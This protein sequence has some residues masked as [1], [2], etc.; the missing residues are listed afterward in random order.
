[1]DNRYTNEK[2]IG[3]NN[4][5]SM[6]RIGFGTWN[7]A[8]GKDV[9]EAVSEA[10]KVGYRLIDTASIY[11]NER[12]VGEAIRKSKIPREEIYVTTKLWLSDFMRPEAAFQDS[13]NKLG[14][15]Y[16]DLYLVHWPVPLMSS[17][18]WGAMVKI[19]GAGK[20]R[21]IGVSNYSVKQIKRILEHYPVLPV[22][23]Q[24]KF[25]P[26]YY[27]A[28]ILEF[29]QAND[30]VVEAYSPLTHGKNLDDDIIVGISKRY[31][32]SPAQLLIR[33][34]LQKGTVV[35][36]K[37]SNPE[38][39]KSNFEVFDFEISK[40]DMLVLDGLSSKAKS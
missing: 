29:C 16:V 15:D 19:Y 38:R 34:A 18:I 12:G 6:P 40:S 39:I 5:L 26:F 7:I 36:P 3:L 4:G 28:E 35:I 8:D 13:L 20:A 30:I 22:V 33:W 2:I 31:G 11:H 32:K 17:K 23:N 25:N 21:A 27:D 24:I 9:E 1:M 10:L 37:S 14:L